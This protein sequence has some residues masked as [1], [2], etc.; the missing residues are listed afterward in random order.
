MYHKMSPKSRTDKPIFIAACRSV[1]YADIA[2]YIKGHPEKLVSFVVEHLCDD[3]MRSFA[4][5]LYRWLRREGAFGPWIR[6]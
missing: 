1:P 5:A 4:R 6:R 2:H 3:D